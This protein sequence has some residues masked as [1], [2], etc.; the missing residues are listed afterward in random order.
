MP[1]STI[2][3][4]DTLVREWLERI[5]GHEGGFTQNP[6]DKG[7]W[8]GG[9]VGAGK[10][11]GTKF[12]ISAAAYPDLDI[13]S[14]TMAQ[15]SDIYQRDY[16]RPI[17]AG[18]FRDGVAFQ[19]VDTAA[20]SGPKTAVKL[21]QKA[22]GVA[23]DG[24]VGPVTLARLAELSESDVI[25]LVLAERIDF[26]ARLGNFVTFARGWMRRIASNLRYGAVDS[27]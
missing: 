5:F 11:H 26:L 21:L 1:K 22:I 18:R 3:I 25:M 15:A 7:N 20:H 13:K 24:F 17:G 2:Y 14:L 12:G 9:K 27:D 23:D 19:L 16:L 6:A 8:T 4:P 10:L